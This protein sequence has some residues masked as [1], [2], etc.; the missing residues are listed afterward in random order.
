MEAKLYSGKIMDVHTHFT[1]ETTGMRR[2]PESLAI[3]SRIKVLVNM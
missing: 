3:R 2:M 1:I